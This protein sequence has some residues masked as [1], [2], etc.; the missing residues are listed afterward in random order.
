M[1]WDNYFNSISKNQLLKNVMDQQKDLYYEYVGG[2]KTDNVPILLQN[3]F[4]LIIEGISNV[5]LQTKNFEDVWDYITKNSQFE[6][7]QFTKSLYY[8]K[9]EDSIDIIN[10]YPGFYF[11]ENDHGTGMRIFLRIYTLKESKQFMSDFRRF[12]SYHSILDKKCDEVM[13]EFC[14]RRTMEHSAKKIQKA[15][16]NWLW[17]PIC[18]D[19][20][21]GI[22][23]RLGWKRISELFD[24]GV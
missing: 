9:Y 18:K 4:F 17:K 22:N 12:S 2:H 20:S 8:I 13:L 11:T 6:M 5:N 24:T 21:H 3:P 7:K 1:T 19:G 14:K 10:I 15:C 16:H 23:M